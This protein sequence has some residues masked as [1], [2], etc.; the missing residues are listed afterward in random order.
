MIPP[1]SRRLVLAGATAL[2]AGRAF[3]AEDR[4]ALAGQPTQGGW[5]RGHVPVGT[6]ALHLD[7][8]AVHFADD[9][10]F[11]IAFDRDSGASP[12]LVAQVPGGTVRQVLAISPR[13][14]QIQHVDTPMH[15]GGM[16]DAEFARRRA[17][18]LAQIKAAR[19]RESISDGWRQPMI[20]PA[21]G[22][23][24]GRFGAQRIFQG[25]PAAYHGG[26]DI[27]AP[28]GAAMSMPP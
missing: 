11:L 22:P 15:P 2:W 5:L 21:A 7:E 26:M 17:G 25:V 13:N 16:P 10:A 28:A 19:A 14:W 3:G 9:G 8:T 6:T 23:I 12:E 18:E 4:F 20:H 1:V 27:A 24:S